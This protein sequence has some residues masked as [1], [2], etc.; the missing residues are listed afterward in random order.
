MHSYAVPCLIAHHNPA[1]AL[2]IHIASSI[3]QASALNPCAYLS[4]LVNPGNKV[5]NMVSSI[6]GVGGVAGVEASLPFSVDMQ[7][8][9][10]LH[11]LLPL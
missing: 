2:C 9:L 5:V 6:C 8:M 7:A 4:K 3:R 10:L 1:V 11:V